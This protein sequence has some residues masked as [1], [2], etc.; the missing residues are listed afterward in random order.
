[1]FSGIIQGIG[2]I[3]YLQSKNSF[4]I[5]SLDLSDCKIG[6]SISCN[7]VCLTATTVDKLENYDLSNNVNANKNEYIIHSPSFFKKPSYI[8]I[9]NEDQLSF[10][11]KNYNNNIVYLN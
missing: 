1:M 5:T 9:T 4:I 11:K 7:G 6:S 8:V 2:F 3:D 10:V